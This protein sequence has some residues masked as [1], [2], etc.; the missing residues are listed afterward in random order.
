MLHGL[1]DFS[2][3]NPVSRA[4]REGSASAAHDSRKPFLLL[5][6]QR[7]HR[8]PGGLRRK[9]LDLDVEERRG[10]RRKE[11]RRLNQSKKF[12]DTKVG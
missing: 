12:D 7:M 11:K 5:N 1:L 3:A 2:T 10:K 8:R 4:C 9:Q 6:S